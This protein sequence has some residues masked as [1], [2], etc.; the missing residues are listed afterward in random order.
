MSR[1]HT[2]PTSWRLTV[3][4][5]LGCRGPPWAGGVPGR[6]P[7]HPRSYLYFQH[8]RGST[9]DVRAVASRAR[10]LGVKQAKRF[11]VGDNVIVAGAS[12]GVCQW[13]S[14]FPVAVVHAKQHL[15]SAYMQA[16]QSRAEPLQ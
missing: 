6:G 12:T 3:G 14:G 4:K 1:A 7:P 8:Y 2:G 9:A 13:P 15:A 11:A 10:Y 5:S 16:A